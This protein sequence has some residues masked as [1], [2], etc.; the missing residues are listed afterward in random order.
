[1]MEVG[2]ILFLSID[3]AAN[4]KSMYVDGSQIGSS[5]A[6]PT[7]TGASFDSTQRVTMGSSYNT[8]CCLSDIIT[9]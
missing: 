4:A 2:I 3:Q 5:I 9:K 7:A 8:D 6:L 1:M